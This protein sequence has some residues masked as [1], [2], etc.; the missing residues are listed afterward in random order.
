MQSFWKYMFFLLILGFQIV[1][2]NEKIYHLNNDN[3]ADIDL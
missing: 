1:Y 3:R 2:T